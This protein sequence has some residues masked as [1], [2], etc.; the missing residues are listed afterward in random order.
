MRFFQAHQQALELDLWILS[1]TLSHDRSSHRRT[2]H[3]QRLEMA[4]TCF[5]RYGLNTLFVDW[6][7]FTTSLKTVKQQKGSPS[8]TNAEAEIGTIEGQS[9]KAI[10]DASRE[11]DLEFVLSLLQDRAIKGI[12]EFSSRSFH[13][14]K[15][16]MV[17]MARGFFLPFLTV[18]F[19]SLARLRVLSVR[20]Q[21]QIKLVEIPKLLEEKGNPVITLLRDNLERFMHAIP[22]EKLELNCNTTS[23]TEDERY[24]RSL[25]SLGLSL[26]KSAD[27][28]GKQHKETG[29]EA[30]QR[31]SCVETTKKRNHPALQDKGILDDDIGEAMSSPKK[32]S[33]RIAATP[34][35][36]PVEDP[37]DGNAGC[38][39]A[40]QRKKKTVA[41]VASSPSKR[42]KS[43]EVQGPKKK[44][45]K[46]KKK[47]AGG[48]FFDELFG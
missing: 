16:G 25:A 46:R 21:Q 5:L 33:P 18:S 38:L 24:T 22:L 10:R 7:E 20:L 37:M 34:T 2:I 31:G 39:K 27:S 13:A 28:E 8:K 9:S 29:T 44:R 30:N 42:L 6:N 43:S 32:K 17:E 36:G 47:D 45:T 4:K 12:S 19:A 23:I 26:P 15:Y 3:F 14:S 40:L 48:D 11:E 41:S 1:S 35:Q